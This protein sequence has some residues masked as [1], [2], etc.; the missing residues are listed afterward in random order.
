M[1]LLRGLPHEPEDYEWHLRQAEF[2]LA[3]V[4]MSGTAS[5]RSL[6]SPECHQHAQPVLHTRLSPN[7]EV[8]ENLLA[9]APAMELEFRSLLAKGAIEEVSDDEVRQ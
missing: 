2:D 9:R 5:L 6:G 3:R 1:E 4:G 7:E 8:R